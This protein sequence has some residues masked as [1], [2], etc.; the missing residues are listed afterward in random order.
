MKFKLAGP[1][2]GDIKARSMDARKPRKSEQQIQRLAP[3]PETPLWSRSGFK[4][5]SESAALAAES[6]ESRRGLF[7]GEL[8]P[9]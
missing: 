2:L 7:V 8:T 6:G 4:G 1:R 9:R 3:S 5:L